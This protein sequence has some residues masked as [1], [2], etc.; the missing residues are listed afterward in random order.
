MHRAA[1]I[2]VAISC[3]SGF[4][5]AAVHKTVRIAEGVYALRPAAEFAGEEP[6]Q[7]ANAAFVVGP[8]G[9][10][11]I[12]TGISYRE[13]LDIIAAVRRVTRRPIRLVILTHPSQEAIFG[14]AAFQARGVPILMHRDAAALMASRCES[15]LRS[16]KAALGEDAMAGSRVV[17]PDRLIAGD[18]AIDAIGRRLRVIAPARSSAPG[19]LAV[20]DERTSTLIAG[21]LVSIRSVPD[22]RDADARGWR[23]ALA[24]LAAT[25]CRHLVGSYGAIGRCADIDS[26][27]RYFNDLETR[28]AALMRDGIGLAELGERCDMPGYAS[29]DRYE[30]LHRANASRTYLRLERALFD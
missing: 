5:D 28:V 3:A 15:C 25:R 20:L 10:A 4:A 30:A 8:R 26:F 22:T 1:V 9:V 27:A 17:V 16:L 24:V 6:F 13:G 14:A 2:A 29:W 7:R 23:D 19:A 12:D 18:E 21:S 11:V